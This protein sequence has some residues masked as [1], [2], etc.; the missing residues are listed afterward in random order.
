M[1]EGYRHLEAGEWASALAV[2]EQLRAQ[3]FSGGYELLARAHQALGDEDRALELLREGLQRTPEVWVLWLLK[4]E[5]HSARG[6]VDDARSGFQRALACPQV[7]VSAVHLAQALLLHN[8]GQY[9]EALAL[10][11]AI[12]TLPWRAQAWPLRIALLI[13]LQR[14]D[15]AIDLEEAAMTDLEAL[16]DPTPLAHLHAQIGQAWWQGHRDKAR[17]RLSA[18][19]SL[20]QNPYNEDALWLLR[21]ARQERAKA[22]RRLK[23]VVTGRWPKK[24]GR[25]RE[26]FFRIYQVVVDGPGEALR[27]IEELEPPTLIGSL[28]VEGF[29]RLAS[30]EEPL[31]GVEARSE[32]LARVLDEDEED[33]D[34][35]EDEEEEEE[36]T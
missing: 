8:T 14:Y 7:D 32:Y 16:D 11:E 31:K 2:G 26:G 35:D 15:Q 22:A 12:E 6:E 1:E 4:G 36:A 23:V 9:L 3:A 25:P 18:L 33:E 27:F 30:P 10:A 34:E 21:Q 19:A 28:E 5:L 20:Q 24:E 13:A 17:A 29:E